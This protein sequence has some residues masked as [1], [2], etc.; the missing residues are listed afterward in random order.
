[1]RHVVI[2]QVTLDIDPEQVSGPDDAAYQAQ[3]KLFAKF[4][5]RLGPGM[6][7]YDVR[8]VGGWVDADGCLVPV[9]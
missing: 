7:V 8:A 5:E 6:E 3:E 4:P 9:K 2:L 1:M